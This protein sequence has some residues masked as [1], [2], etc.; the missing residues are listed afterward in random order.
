MRGFTLHYSTKCLEKMVL[1][2]KKVHGVS[3][4]FYSKLFVLWILVRWQWNVLKISVINSRIVVGDRFFPAMTDHSFSNADLSNESRR[5]SSSVSSRED[6]GY[7]SD[8]PDFSIGSADFADLED[9]AQSFVDGMQ[10]FYGHHLSQMR[11]QRNS[12]TISY[13]GNCASCTF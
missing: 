2:L 9:S 11:F 6:L 10:I 1:V 8:K 5:R 7:Y 4:F 3:C 13:G 12:I